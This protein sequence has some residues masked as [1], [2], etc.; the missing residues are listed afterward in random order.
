MKNKQ[1]FFE[2]RVFLSKTNYIENIM[3]KSVLNVN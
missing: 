1:L 3:F 2:T